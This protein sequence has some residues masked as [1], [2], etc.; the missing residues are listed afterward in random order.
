[1]VWL[2]WLKHG[3]VVGSVIFNVFSGKTEK[4]DCCKESWYFGTLKVSYSRFFVSFALF[5]FDKI[6]VADMMEGY[7]QSSKFFCRTKYNF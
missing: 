6:R 1:M 3:T 7:L 2:P 5:N 4:D